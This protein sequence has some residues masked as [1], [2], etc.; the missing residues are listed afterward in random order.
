[1]LLHTHMH[2]RTLMDRYKMVRVK[3]IKNVQQQSGAVAP[4]NNPRTQE[5]NA[6]GL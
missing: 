4:G 2:M 5:A 1:M 6:G 3:S